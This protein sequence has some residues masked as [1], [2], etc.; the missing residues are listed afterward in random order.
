ME[1]CHFKVYIQNNSL[2]IAFIDKMAEWLRRWTVNP[3]GSASVGSNPIFVAFLFGSMVKWIA[4]FSLNS[5]IKVQI[6]E[7]NCY[8]QNLSHHFFEIKKKIIIIIITEER[9]TSSAMF[10]MAS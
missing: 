1:I 7:K 4:I 10:W 8:L 2:F 3:L 5:A 6:L 9:I